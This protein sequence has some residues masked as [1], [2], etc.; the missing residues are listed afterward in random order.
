MSQLP[1][2]PKLSVQE[3]LR[4]LHSLG[5]PRKITTENV[6]RSNHAD[7][8]TT[9]ELVER[10]FSGLRKNEL[11]STMELWIDGHIANTAPLTASGDIREADLDRLGAETLG[12]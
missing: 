6:R 9:A 2:K 12:L 5:D 4:A 8:A 11:A 3:H 10:R 1:Q 7:F